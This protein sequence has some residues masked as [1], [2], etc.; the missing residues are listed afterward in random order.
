MVPISGF[1]YF[2]EEFPFPDG[3]TGEKLFVVLCDSPLDNS[4]VLAARTTSK[5]K[6]P[7]NQGCHPDGKWPNFFVPSTDRSFRKDTWIQFDYVVEMESEEVEKQFPKPLLKLSLEL[8]TELVECAAQSRLI[9]NCFR[10][11]CSAHARNM[12][13]K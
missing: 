1:V 9:E 12:K 8:T 10:E 7:K 13:G 4:N 5:P 3:V 11:A 2:D 6:G